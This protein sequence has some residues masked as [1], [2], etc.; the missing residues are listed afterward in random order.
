MKAAIDR[1]IRGAVATF[2]GTAG[3]WRDRD[4]ATI[5]ALRREVHDLANRATVA[6]GLIEML[7]IKLFLPADTAPAKVMAEA[8]RRLP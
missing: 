7:A 6:E 4:T 8:L 5:A 1:T 2:A 3:A